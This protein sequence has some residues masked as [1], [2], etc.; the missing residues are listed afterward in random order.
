MQDQRAQLEYE[1]AVRMQ[2][3]KQK[4]EQ[5]L[6]EEMNERQRVINQQLFGDSINDREAETQ[7]MKSNQNINKLY[8]KIE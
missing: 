4:K 1:K 7:F 5:T 6:E 8:K 2:Y 3:E